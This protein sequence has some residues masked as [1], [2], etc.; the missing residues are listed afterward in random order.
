MRVCMLARQHCCEGRVRRYVESL[1]AYGVEVDV[2]RLPGPEQ[3]SRPVRYAS[4]LALAA[5]LAGR[6]LRRRYDAVHVVGMP[7]V[8][9]LAALLSR[10]AGTRVLIDVGH[11]PEPHR[12]GVEP[13]SSGRKVRF[14]ELE[15]WVSARLADQLITLDDRFARRLVEQGVPPAKI[16]VVRQ[17]GDEEADRYHC[18]VRDLVVTG[19]RRP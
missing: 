17:D 11:G 16:A 5:H 8:S 10:L 7:D 2:L 15:Q 1:R 19:P 4:G 9:L 14:T 6:H 18:V 13:V 12:A 3:A